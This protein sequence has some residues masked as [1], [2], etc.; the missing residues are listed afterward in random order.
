MPSTLENVS[1]IKRKLSINVPAAE[2]DQEAKKRLVEVS[3]QARIPGFRPGKAPIDVIRK[4]YG[5]SIRSEIITKLIEKS[6]GEALMEHKLK[7]AGMPKI[8]IEEAS[9]KAGDLKYTAELEVFPEFSVTGLDKLKLTKLTCTIEDADLDAMF[10]KLRKQHISWKEAKRAAK[11]EDRLTIDFE[12][13]KGKE[14]FAGGKAEDFKIILGSKTMIPGFEDALIGK[15]ADE[16]FD[17]K[18]T[19]PE[20]YHAAELKGQKVTFKIKVKA[21]EEPVLPKVD[22]AFAKLFDVKDLATLKKEVKVNMERELDF[23]LK[24]KLK[25]QV[26]E[27]LLEHNKVELPEALVQEEAQRLA[28]GAQ[29][30]MKSWGQQQG[31]SGKIADMP[32]DLFMPEAQKRVALGLIMNRI[33]QDYKLQPDQARIDTMVEKMASIYDNPAEVIQFFKNNKQRMAEIEQVVLE[34]QV[35]DEVAKLAKVVEEKQ[36][37]E[38][39]MENNVSA[40]ANILP[41]G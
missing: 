23:T 40:M 25:D 33:I 32:L 37:F 19:F 6:Y 39:V 8:N 10:E 1:N 38:K 15:K 2:I 29:E 9:F 28:Q 30:R 17:M 22:E 41:Q 14:A 12:G 36:G 3:Q 31:Q 4:Q 20:D 35:V 11:A 13:F 5:A 21:V 7:P 16:E 18:L 34:E 27:G 24:A 26:I